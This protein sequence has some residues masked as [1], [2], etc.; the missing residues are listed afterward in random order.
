LST[1]SEW[2]FGVLGIPKNII[3]WGGDE[4]K[5]LPQNSPPTEP[6]N[7]NAPSTTK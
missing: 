4:R 3:G 1:L 5:E 2:V 6:T 7:E